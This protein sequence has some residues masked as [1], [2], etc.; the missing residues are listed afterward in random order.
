MES[1]HLDKFLLSISTERVLRFFLKNNIITKAPG[2]S[3]FYFPFQFGTSKASIIPPGILYTSFTMFCNRVY[4]YLKILN[5][6]T[7]NFGVL[8][9]KYNSKTK[10]FEYIPSVQWR[11]RTNYTL[12]GVWTLGASIIIVKYKNLKDI[13]RFNLGLSYWLFGIL[14]TAVY[15]AYLWFGEDICRIFNEFT[16]FMGYMHSKK[17]LCKKL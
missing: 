11:V 14:A 1:D 7:L 2:I 4:R 9:G 16:H 10:R 3:S 8:A 17:N 13:D 15:T 12:F 5:F 6:F